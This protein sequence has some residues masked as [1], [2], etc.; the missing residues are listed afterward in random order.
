MAGAACI[1]CKL[2]KWP[3]SITQA[4]HLL[5]FLTGL[6]IATNAHIVAATESRAWSPTKQEQHIQAETP[7][8]ETMPIA[9][10]KQKHEHI[11]DHR[12]GVFRLTRITRVSMR[13]NVTFLY[14]WA[15]GILKLRFHG[16][17]ALSPLLA[18]VS[19]M[20]PDVLLTLIPDHLAQPSCCP[21]KVQSAG[22][23]PQRA[24]HSL[25]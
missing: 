23:A 5:T 8:N 1:Q 7:E 2:N 16:K 20:M 21:W 11:A 18:L 12:F 17:A 3:T 19:S 15:R 10:L 14:P 6:I 4:M 13:P 9:A 25:H 22:T 24:C